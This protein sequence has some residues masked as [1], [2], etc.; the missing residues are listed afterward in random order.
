MTL[1]ST[2][3]GRLRSTNEMLSQRAAKNVV[4]ELD[5]YYYPHH[6]ALFAGALVFM[7]RERDFAVRL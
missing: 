6:R 7:S 3:A 4:A 5:N 1:L 2:L